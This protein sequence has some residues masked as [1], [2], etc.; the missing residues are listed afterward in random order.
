MF[1]LQCAHRLAGATVSTLGAL[2]VLFNICMLLA[3][4]QFFEQVND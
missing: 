2:L 4:M 3:C 1:M